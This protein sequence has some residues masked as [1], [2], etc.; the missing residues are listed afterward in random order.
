MI[1]ACMPRLHTT[2]QQAREH[3]TP[4]EHQQAL[5][6]SEGSPA[7][8]V[9]GPRQQ[10]GPLT[11]GR[12]HGHCRAPGARSAK[13]SGRGGCDSGPW[14]CQ[15]EGCG[16]AGGQPGAGGGRH[17]RC[18]RGEGGRGGRKGGGRRGAR[19]ARVAA[20]AGDARGGEEGSE[21]AL[22]LFF[23]M[24]RRRLQPSTRTFNAV[25]G[26]L[27]REQ[28]WH[29]MDTILSSMKEHHQQADMFTYNILISA[30]CKARRLSGRPA[31]RTRRPL[32]GGCSRPT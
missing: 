15:G 27:G 29:H 12:R 16:C 6:Q 32:R 19:R 5:Q 4:T 20:D 9:G 28:R 2:H 10:P 3:Q 31:V 8:A 7:Q 17:T 22:W 26:V 1:G 14:G 13:Q 25:L 23:E 30:H 21:K 24:Q 18:R 11:P